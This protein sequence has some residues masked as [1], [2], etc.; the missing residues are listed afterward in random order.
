MKKIILLVLMIG[1]SINLIAISGKVNDKSILNTLSQSANENSEVLNRLNKLLNEDTIVLNKIETK[2]KILALVILSILLLILM[3]NYSK[4]FQKNIFQNSAKW[5]GIGYFLVIIAFACLYNIF[6]PNL[7]ISWES[8][9][10]MIIPSIFKLFL[11]SFYYSVV[12]I[13]TL[14]FGDISP[15]NLWSMLFTL[16]ESLLGIMFIGLFLNSL[17]H[18][19]SSKEEEEKEKV[20]IEAMEKESKKNRIKNIEEI[21][22]YDKFLNNKLNNFWFV[23][24]SLATPNNKYTL[25]IEK[26]LWNENFEFKD[27]CE[28]SKPIKIDFN[29]GFMESKIDVYFRKEKKINK[30]IERILLEVN[31]E[32]FSELEKICSE[33]LEKSNKYNRENSI[34]SSKETK[35][36]NKPLIEFE[37]E[38][39][40]EYTKEP[41]FESHSNVINKYIALY[42]Q[43]K[44]YLS[45]RYKYLEE[46][47]K[48]KI[49][50]SDLKK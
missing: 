45:F 32:N 29:N 23:I 3:Y 21:L 33:V 37:Q 11:I 8:Y 7:I 24:R 28:L 42:I 15:N 40:K 48:I 18:E 47:R 35:T 26:G 30:L 16:I 19:R 14:G 44:T 27:L 2:E 25:N 6:T 31:L 43:I 50:L 12:T 38:M 1:L 10:L 4:I 22:R 46:I 49:I 17:S 39:I 13:T 20:I 36:G 41:K 34:L 9:S 5:Y